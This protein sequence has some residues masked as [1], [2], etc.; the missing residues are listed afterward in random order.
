MMRIYDRN[1]IQKQLEQIYTHN[2]YSTVPT[3]IERKKISFINKNKLK[4]IAFYLPQYYP[5]KINNQNWGNGFT[6]WT[7]VAKAIPQYYGHYQPHIPET[8]GYY[9]LRNVNIMEEQCNLAKEYGIFGFCFYYYYFQGKT[10]LEVPLNNYVNDSNINFPFC[11]CWANENWTKK[12]DGKDQ[13]IL[14]QQTYTKK[15]MEMFIS[16]ISKYFILDNYIK[17]NQRPLLIIYNAQGIPDLDN[18]IQLWREF[19]L[20]AGIGD[21]FLVCAKTFGL[22]DINIINKFDACVEF[23]PHD[24]RLENKIDYSLLTNK[25]FNGTI[26]HIYDYITTMNNEVNYPLFRCAFPSWDNTARTSARAKIFSDANP[27]TFEMWLKKI[28][29]FTIE[30]HTSEHRY[31]F[32][33]AWNEWG[34]GAHLEPDR[35]YGFAYLEKLRQ[36]LEE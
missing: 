34:E 4:P 22:D 20:H 33:N 2:I 16:K 12:W 11:L 9:D 3:Y 21:I 32:I 31:F 24:I 5:T 25:D 19:C 30:L 8:F 27:V 29:R 28:I 23:P 36:C 10:Q 26:Y 13:E 1:I 6:E 15:D 17:I 18:C 14:L 7:N 35:K